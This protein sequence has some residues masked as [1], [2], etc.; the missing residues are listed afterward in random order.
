MEVKSVHGG[1][2]AYA[3]DNRKKN[4]QQSDVEKVLRAVQLV[5]LR[6]SEEAVK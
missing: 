4:V 1:R 6:R 3:S 2:V 5:G